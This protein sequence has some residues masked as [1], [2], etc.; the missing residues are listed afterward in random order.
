MPL[1]SAGYSSSTP[2]TN[3]QVSWPT[4]QPGQ[5]SPPGDRKRGPDTATEVLLGTGG[6]QLGMPN[7]TLFEEIVFEQL[8]E[9]P[10]RYDPYEEV[11]KVTAEALP[12]L[13]ERVFQ[14]EAMWADRNRLDQNQ[15]KRWTDAVKMF[16][17]NLLQ[18][19]KQRKARLK[20]E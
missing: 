4:Q 12:Q 19:A 3:A 11:E 6:Q 20:E 18:Q 15:W 13:F 14:G 2:T 17:A 10:F 9:N 5:A 1:T 7:R 8:G 16:R